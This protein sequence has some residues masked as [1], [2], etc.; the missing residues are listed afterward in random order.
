[1][2][3]VEAYLRMVYDPSY[4]SPTILPFYPDIALAIRQLG[5]KNGLKATIIRP[6]HFFESRLEMVHEYSTGVMVDI[7]NPLL[8]T[9][10]DHPLLVAFALVPSDGNGGIVGVYDVMEDHEIKIITEGEEIV[11]LS[12]QVEH[13]TIGEPFPL[14]AHSW[15]L[16]RAIISGLSHQHRLRMTKGKDL[17]K[18]LLKVVSS[19]DALDPPGEIQS[20]LNVEV[21][22]IE[23]VEK[24]TWL[25]MDI[26]T[27]KKVLYPLIEIELYVHGD[28][29][30]SALFKA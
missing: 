18:Y 20:P 8:P 1:M 25:I 28:H 6:Q 17:P 12:S 22:T 11:Q 26:L 5:E 10:L 29:A 21:L 3:E 27:K 14:I 24:I 23:G 19:I 4:V 2:E 13:T 16:P 30:L 9:K 7:S 15:V